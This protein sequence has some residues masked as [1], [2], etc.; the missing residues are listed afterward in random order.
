MSR[1]LPASLEAAPIEP[2]Q[3][4]AVKGRERRRDPG[5]DHF[6]RANA[7]SERGCAAAAIDEYTLALQINPSFATG[8]PHPRERTG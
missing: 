4:R 6:F 8:T 3:K 2:V 7:L 5:T 1:S